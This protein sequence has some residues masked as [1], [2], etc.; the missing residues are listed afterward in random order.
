MRFKEEIGMVLIFAFLFGLCSFSNS[1]IS[2]KLE[3]G[4]AIQG[5]IIGAVFAAIIIFTTRSGD[6]PFW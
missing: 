2:D 3:F 4:M 1:I 5:L 6:D